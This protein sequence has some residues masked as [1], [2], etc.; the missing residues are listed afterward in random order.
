MENFWI[1][2]CP[3]E[4]MQGDLLWERWFEEK[5]VAVGFPPP[6]CSFDRPAGVGGWKEKGWVFAK[7]RLTEMKVGDKVIAFA[8]NWRIGP[9]GTVTAIRVSDDEWNP[10]IRREELL[11][12]HDR[13]GRPNS[14]VGRRIEVE[15]DTQTDGKLVAIPADLRTKRPLARHTIERLSIERFTELRTV[16]STK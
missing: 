11:R 16:V 2:I 4:R 3:V 1:V 14:L 6:E 13:K 5:C 10:T 7:N 8:G 12:T 9:V 15:W